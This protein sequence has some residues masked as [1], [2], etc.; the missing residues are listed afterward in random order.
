M[1]YAVV[2]TCGL[3]GWE[4]YGRRMVQTFDQYWPADIPLYLYAEDFQPDHHRPIVRR[5]PTWLTEFKARHAEHPYAH[6]LANG[7]YDPLF[8]S[9]RYAHKASAAS[10]AALTLDVDILIV[11]DADILTHAPVDSNWL[12]GLFPPESYIAWL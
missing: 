12:A 2:T 1:R 3:P 4:L 5:L 8:D 6:G 7:K 10:D 9:V 11:A